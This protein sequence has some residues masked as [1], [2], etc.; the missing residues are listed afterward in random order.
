MNMLSPPPALPAKADRQLHDLVRTGDIER[1]ADALDAGAD[2]NLRDRWGMTL[3]LLAVQHRRAEAIPILGRAGADPGAVDGSDQTV[4]D[5]ARRR[6]DALA[7]TA[8]RRDI[9][10][11]CP[12]GIASNA[13]A[14]ASNRA[15]RPDHAMERGKERKGVK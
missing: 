11:A 15:E 13:V 10:L 5:L 14:R 6:P 7:I 9:P 2:P 3:L 1:L 4:M 8:H 12:S